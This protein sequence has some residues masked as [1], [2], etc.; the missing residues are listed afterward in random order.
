MTN[1]REQGSA[2]RPSVSIIIL[3]YNGARWLDRCLGSLRSQTVFDRIEVIV[4]D[5]A[6]PDG[7]ADVAAR[8][9]EGWGNGR[10][11]RFDRNLGFCEG[12]N[13][14]ART[15][16]GEYLFFLNNDTWLEPDCLAVLLEG[17]RREGVQVATPLMLNYEDSTIQSSGGAGFDLFG[18]MS[19]APCELGE[20]RRVFVAG[21]CCYLIQEGLFRKL[22]GFDRAFFM[23][24]D[25][26]D[27][28]WRIWIAGAEALLVPAARLHHRG[29]ASVNP[30]GGGKVLEVRTSD[31]KRFYTNRNCLLLLLKNCQH[32]LLAMVPLQIAL[33][34]LEALAG[35]VMIRRWS[36]VKRAYIDAILACWGLR[37]HILAERRLLASVR[38]RSDWQMLSFFRCR[39]NRWE[40]V[41]NVLRNGPPKVTA[42]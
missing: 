20:T 13:E 9:M 30:T 17:V 5:N 28:S 31:S 33:L 7:S 15:A 27:L 37:G 10:V 34:C 25:E 22:G 12:N 16:S 21:G 24:G 4:A 36:F 23:Y 41:R 40:E 29:A 8:L 3:N 18:L 11:L 26:Y 6:S 2:A 35:L 19:L 1:C 14:A 39:L 32:L 38:Q 42:G